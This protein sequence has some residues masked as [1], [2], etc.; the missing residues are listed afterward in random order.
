MV[1]SWLV[2]LVLKDLLVDN[3]EEH[4]D[5]HN[6]DHDQDDDY[7]DDYHDDHHDDYHVDDDND[8]DDEIVPGEETISV[9]PQHGCMVSIAGTF[10]ISDT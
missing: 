7:D 4:G 6:D 9:S 2:A 1:G 8:D 5:S 3:D 10:H